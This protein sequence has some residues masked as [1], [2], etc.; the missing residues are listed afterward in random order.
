LLFITNVVKV[1]IQLNL[2]F[3]NPSRER[4][5]IGDRSQGKVPKRKQK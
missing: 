2:K 3:T 1:D 5:W 4:E